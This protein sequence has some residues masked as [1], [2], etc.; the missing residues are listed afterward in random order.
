MALG[1][2]RG[3]LEGLRTLAGCWVTMIEAPRVPK[4]PAKDVRILQASEA[5][6]LEDDETA[7]VVDVLRATSTIAVALENGASVVYPVTTPEA[8]RER[9]EAIE[10]ALL[11][12][13]RNRGV[14][15]GFVDNSPAKLARMDLEGRE[16]VLTTTNGTHALLAARG[17]NRVLAGGL[18]NAS[19]IASSVGGE[20]VAL[21]A[22]G[23]R[24]AAAE[25]DDACCA[26]LAGLL[27]G[28]AV[29]VEDAL[30]ALEASTSAVKLREAGKGA[31]V[32]ACLSVD[33]APVI[34]V[35]EGERL[36]RE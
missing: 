24:G 36:V 1:R 7:I 11:V 23:W 6:D 18:V 17:A 14:L 12:G 3:G 27:S 5:E 20:R 2:G 8:A 35:L 26:F 9:G 28:E 32:D 21:V 29:S 25:D 33:T 10:G 22:A 30:S 31:D 34:P 4:T 13:E 19:R 15:D 16:V